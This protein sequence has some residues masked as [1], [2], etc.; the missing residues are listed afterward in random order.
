MSTSQRWWERRGLMRDTARA[1]TL[2]LLASAALLPVWV[3]F[4]GRIG[5]DARGAVL[6]AE[7][8]VDAVGTRHDA[9]SD[10]RDSFDVSGVLEV[11]PE[12][13]RGGVEG[14]VAR[15]RLTQSQD[16]EP[17][18]IDDYHYVFSAD[19]KPYMD[20]QSVALYRS[21]Q[22][23][24]SPGMITRLLSC[25]EHTLASY[26]YLDLMP[27][28]V[29]P[30]YGDIDPADSY[31][32]YN[33]PGSMLHFMEHAKDA[34]ATKWIV[35]L[36]ADMILRKPLTVTQ[37]GLTAGPG[38]VA[39]GFYGYLEGVDNEMAAM[40]VEDAEIRSRLA[41]VGGWEIFHAP[42]LARAAPLWF[43]YTK[44]VR[45]DKRVWW[46]FKGTGDVFITE[47]NPRPWISEMYGYVF[48]SA[49]AGLRHNVVHSCQLYG[50]M[51]PWD[52]ASFDP[53]L[54][55]YGILIEIPDKS[56]T[57]KTAWQW[58]KH[59]ELQG[60]NERARDKLSCAV[61]FAPFPEVPENLVPHPP[62]D[63][64][65]LTRD[66]AETRRVEIV[67]ELMRALNEGVRWHRARACGETSSLNGE[68]REALDAGADA[69]LDGD[70]RAAAASEGVSRRKAK[71]SIP[72]R[73]AGRTA[74]KDGGRGEARD[75]LP[76]AR[77]EAKLERQ[78]PRLEKQK[79]ELEKP[80]N[81]ETRAFLGLDRES[82]PDDAEEDEDLR[83]AWIAFAFL[84]GA[85]L[86][87]V[88][89]VACG[90]SNR[91]GAVVRRRVGGIAR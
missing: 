57:T 38:V 80:S 89:R 44:K 36:D 16:A 3:V 69:G 74:G 9:S 59:R 34:L 46:P 56:G 8:R 76:A 17:R 40:F 43:E 75:A 25:D 48:G 22:N 10:A 61:P 54:V 62:T 81:R 18:E 63:G 6:D 83:A 53:F 32:A 72:R 21:W 5:T 1:A 70:R 20:W 77:D 29:T 90:R 66:N 88:T 52:D 11:N 15:R 4:G 49:M 24:G 60:E 39:A 27:T 67:R 13:Y 55:H 26:R 79:P 71:A 73:A 78:P 68:A 33:L 84:W 47:A 85:A 28:H 12:A 64:K 58:D 37:G 23:V 2:A 19:C 51:A 50:G 41:R 30:S 7:A 86:T 42:D 35:K 82:K 87:Y 45:T 14:S 65:T 91:G 31:A